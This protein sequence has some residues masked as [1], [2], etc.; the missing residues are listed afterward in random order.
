M[1]QIERLDHRL[2]TVFA[3]ITVRGLPAGRRKASA[4]D[5]RDSNIRH[6]I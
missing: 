6:L 1:K 5:G 2:S 4:S 3:T